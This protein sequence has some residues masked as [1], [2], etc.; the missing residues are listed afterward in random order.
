[1]T[2]EELCE[3]VEY[4]KSLNVPKDTEVFISNY[5]HCNDDEYTK[6]S[7]LNFEPN[8]RARASDEKNGFIEIF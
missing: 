5:T 1:M 6:C 2:F 7:G 4:L 8:D 3:E